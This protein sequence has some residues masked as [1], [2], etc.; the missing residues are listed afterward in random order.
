MKTDFHKILRKMSKA[1]EAGDTYLK[2]PEERH[3]RLD[4]EAVA[5]KLKSLM[6]SLNSEHENGALIV[7]EGTRDRR[8]IEQLGF[9][10]RAFLLCHTKNN[11]SVLMVEAEHHKKVILLLDY[12]IEGRKMTGKVTSML[13]DKGINVDLSFR[14]NIRT[15]TCGH[16]EHIQDLSRFIHETSMRN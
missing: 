3:N 14:R 5:E 2:V 8:A 7:V 4:E 13:Q 1:T 11:L 6:L 12:D 15:I 10:G 9:H 16:T